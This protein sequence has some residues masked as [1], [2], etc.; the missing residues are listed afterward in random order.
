[1]DPEITAPFADLAT[2]SRVPIARVT[3]VVSIPQAHAAPLYL[4]ISPVRHPLVA[5][6]A[7][8]RVPLRIFVEVTAPTPIVKSPAFERVASPESV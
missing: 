3:P 2:E 5:K 8:R 4:N 6:S 1:M 7:K